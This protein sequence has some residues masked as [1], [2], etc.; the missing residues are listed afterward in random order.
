MPT[1][2]G[3]VVVGGRFTTINGEAN[4]GLGAVD[5]VTGGTR[6]FA[7]NLVIR[8]AG[9]NASIN[10]LTSVDGVVYGSGYTF[11][12]G[13]NFENTFA[14][15]AATGA[16]AWVSGCRGDTYGTAVVAGVLYTVGHAHDCVTCGAFPQT[17]PWTYQRA[18]AQTLTSDR[19]NIGGSFAGR[20]APAMLHWL[21]TLATG[22]YTGQDQA[23]WS[24]AGNSQ[25]VVLGGEFPLG[26]R[27]RPAGP[28]PVRGHAGRAEP[29][30]P[31]GLRHADADGHRHRA[32]HRPADL[33]RRP[34]TGTT[35]G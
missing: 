5:A 30:G 20:P 11:G 12:G 35:S 18:I 21:P 25:Y 13:G 29:G 9:D 32:R 4:Y 22:T 3:S 26:Q 1:G 17:S 28:G 8:N 6:P 2:T 15:D 24:V 34:G 33:A 10:H 31:A 23:A 7:A 19:T 16:L 27:H 14:A